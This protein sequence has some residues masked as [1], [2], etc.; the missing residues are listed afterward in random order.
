MSHIEQDNELGFGYDP[1]RVMRSSSNHRP[2]CPACKR[3]MFGKHLGAKDERRVL[4]GAGTARSRSGR[5]GRSLHQ[6]A[7]AGTSRQIRR[8]GGEALAGIEDDRASPF[9]ASDEHLR[10]VGREMKKSATVEVRCEACGGTG[11]PAVG[12][13]ET[14]RRIYSASYR[15][16][17]GKRRIR[18]S[19]RRSA[20]AVSRTRPCQDNQL[21]SKS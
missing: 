3:R 18:K 8:Q 10:R 9:A 11:F 7:S 6:K 2:M 12:Q 5:E 17:G 20:A 16:C 13:P 19:Q 1:A 14:G 15:K 21:M 4:Q